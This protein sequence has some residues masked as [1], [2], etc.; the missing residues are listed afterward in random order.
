M[1]ILGVSS[2]N[3]TEHSYLHSERAAYGFKSSRRPSLLKYTKTFS[4]K[5]LVKCF[6]NCYS[7]IMKCV[8]CLFILLSN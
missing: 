3:K 5:V 8:M 4:L 2:I 6:S 7:N 1:Y